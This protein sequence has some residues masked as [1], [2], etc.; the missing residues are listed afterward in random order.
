MLKS[1]K[2]Q[3]SGKNRNLITHTEPKSPT[4]EQF[5]TIRTNI[6][7]S[8]IDTE[9]STILVTSSS[10][11]EGKST[12]ISNLAVTFA[13]QEKKVLLI[14][15]DLR[16]PTTH[17]TFQ[18][19]NYEGLTS[20]LTKG[21]SVGMVAQETKVKNLSVVTSGPIPPNP[22]EL[23][24][25]KAMKRFIQECKQDFDVVLFDMPPILAVT[26][27]QILAKECDGVVLVIRS[28]HA[29][30]ENVKKSKELLDRVGAKILGAVLNG[31][32]QDKN[33]TYYYYGESK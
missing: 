9:I 7:F 10:P 14:D 19:E 26:D 2:K 25:S 20:A 28:G 27:A 11:G 29:E 21:L 4:S 16:K 33:N 12:T 15:A 30:K 5:R 23:L 1:K 17:Y 31:V 13:N 8:A 6:Q 22:S 32:P 18:L 24:S 3:F